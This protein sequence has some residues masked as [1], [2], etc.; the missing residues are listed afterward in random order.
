MGVDAGVGA[1]GH[2]DSGGVKALRKFSRWSL[3][4]MRSLTSSSF[5]MPKSSALPEDV[6]VVVDVHDEVGAVGFGD[7]DA[8]VVDKGGVLDGVDAGVD[9]VFDGLGA[10]CVGGD[11][12]GRPGG[13]CRLPFLVLQGVLEARAGRLC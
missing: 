12:A 10:V 1:E 6:V 4:T 3:P 2:F 5:R 8:F 11:F 13:R 7:G 9:G